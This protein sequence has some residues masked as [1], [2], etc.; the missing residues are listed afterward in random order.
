MPATAH[1]TP[2]DLLNLGTTEERPHITQV[3]ALTAPTPAG[4]QHGRASAITTSTTH[5]TSRALARI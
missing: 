4:L 2:E 1:R 5:Y 3:R